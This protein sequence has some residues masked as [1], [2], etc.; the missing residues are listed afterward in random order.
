MELVLR[1]PLYY[2]AGDT[3]RGQTAGQ[4]LDQFGAEWYVLS[5]TGQKV[6]RS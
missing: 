3:K 5:P 4:G 2:Y 1:H 6:D